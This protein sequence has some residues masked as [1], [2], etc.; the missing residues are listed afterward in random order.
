MR[1]VL[2]TCLCSSVSDDKSMLT[3][4]QQAES[5]SNHHKTR[6]STWLSQYQ[7]TV[8]RFRNIYLVNYYFCQII[9]RNFKL[10]VNH[11]RITEK[12]CNGIK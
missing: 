7:N 10:N 4:S 6:Y 3:E 8:R 11:L 9:D 1:T 12:K 2:M 5:S